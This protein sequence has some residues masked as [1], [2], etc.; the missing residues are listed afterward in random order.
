[1]N[2]QTPPSRLPL[3]RISA[4]MRLAKSIPHSPLLQVDRSALENILLWHLINSS[5]STSTSKVE[6]SDSSYNTTPW[7]ANTIQF[8]STSYLPPSQDYI[9]PVYAALTPLGKVSYPCSCSNA[10]DKNFI[11]RMPNWCRQV[12]LT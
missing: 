12:Y 2:I 9:Q 6:E 8:L 1:M 3:L 10:Y 4:W 7:E 5:L 11:L